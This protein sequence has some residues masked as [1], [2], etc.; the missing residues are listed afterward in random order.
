MQ[1]THG[2]PAKQVAAEAPGQ[3]PAIRYVALWLGVAMSYLIVG[4]LLFV[5]GASLN[6]ELTAVWVPFAIAVAASLLFGPRVGSGSIAGATALELVTGTPLLPALL[7]GVGVGLGATVAFYVIVGRSHRP[8]CM[9]RKTDVLRLTLAAAA[10]ATVATLGAVAA[11]LLQHAVVPGDSHMLGWLVTWGSHGTAVLLIT[12][13]LVY[14]IRDWRRRL[15]H[16]N[17]LELMAAW[18]L[19]AAV[20]VLWQSPELPEAFHGPAALLAIPVFVLIAFRFQMFDMSS[21]MVVF[22]AAGML[23]TLRRTGGMLHVPLSSVQFVL[24]AVAVIGYLLSSMVDEQERAH[25]ELRLAAGV[26]ETSGEGIIVTLPSGEI[27]DVNDAFEKHHGVS[28]QDVIGQ[29]PR[30][31]KS[32]RHPPEFYQ[33]MW[34]S[35]L[36]TGRWQGEVWDRRADGSLIPQ[37]LSISAV[38]NADGETTHYV[39]VASDITVIK[40]SEEKL[41]DLATHDALTGLP[42]RE[43]IKDTL[44]IELAAARRHNKGV[45]LTFFDLD[46][47]KNVNDS[48]GHPQ[49]DALLIEVANRAA[50]VLRES[51]TLGRQGGDEFIAIL[52]EVAVPSE[53]DGL[54]NRLLETVSL[55]YRLGSEEAHVSASIGV[56]VFPEDGMDAATLLKYAEAAMY[57]A[58][59]SGRNRFQYF[60]AEFQEEIDRRVEVERELRH[61]LRDDRFFLL[62]QPQVDLSTGSIV[63]VEAL[64]RMRLDDGTVIPPDGFIPVAESTGLVLPL[65]EWVLRRACA[66]LAIVHN[67]GFDLTVAVNFSARQLRDVDVASLVAEVLKTCSLRPQSLEVEITETALMHAKEMAASKIKDLRDAGVRVALD[68]FG[69]GYSSLTLVQLFRP[70]TVKID[71]QFVS[72]LPDDSEAEAI[73]RAV[74][75]LARAVESCVVAEGPETEAQVR[76][77]RS[78]GCDYAQGY[79]FSRP[80]TLDELMRLLGEGPFTLPG[81]AKRIRGTTTSV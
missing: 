65:G 12:P 62:Y 29:N 57:K 7:I 59:Q 78:N 11:H 31:F 76:F 13:F 5:V 64:V 4:W 58:K 45:G 60:S 74:I 41:R 33:D 46:H 70:D 22:A 56:A 32:G 44:E 15:P 19:L 39:G 1:D 24:S 63:G 61:A 28:R 50:G 52:P 67:A 18:V 6:V 77:L 37:W 54:M 42:N 26:F 47:F 55:P 66:D 10:G 49:G 8:F 25:D 38:K 35:L 9:K 34:D 75:A 73:V 20:A 51:D 68:D 53:L 36:S 40:D 79:F 23:G 3:H 72:A 16:G 81:R 14:M 17:A 48:L 80:V 21:S 71:R 30:I 43:L 2:T 69:T 27:I